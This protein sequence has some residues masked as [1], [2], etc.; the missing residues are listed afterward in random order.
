MTRSSILVFASV[1][2]ALAKMPWQKAPVVV[3]EPE[4]SIM[5]ETIAAILL[6]WGLPAFFLMTTK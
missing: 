5:M 6:C 2:A 1:G 3:A 4:V